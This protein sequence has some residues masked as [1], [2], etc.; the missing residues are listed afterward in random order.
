MT[1]NKQHDKGHAT[2]IAGLA[3][4]V[5]AIFLFVIYKV[6]KRDNT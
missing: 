4:L 2:I 1:N 6:V 3:S 5:V